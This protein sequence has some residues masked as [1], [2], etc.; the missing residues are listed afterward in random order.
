MFNFNANGSFIQWEVGPQGKPYPYLFGRYLVA[1]RTTSDVAQFVNVLPGQYVV[2]T[3][4]A[5]GGVSTRAT[6]AVGS[7]DPVNALAMNIGWLPASSQ[8]KMNGAVSIAVPNAVDPTADTSAP[9][10][11]ALAAADASDSGD[12]ELVNLSQTCSSA[13]MWRTDLRAYCQNDGTPGCARSSAKVC[14][15]MFDTP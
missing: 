7:I 9:S 15:P 2:E 4:D 8:L 12:G 1:K 13:R 6:G 10:A 5:K 14:E 3:T 11:S